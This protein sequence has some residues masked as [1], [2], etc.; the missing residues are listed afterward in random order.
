MT[1]AAATVGVST[2]PAPSTAYRPGRPGLESRVTVRLASL[3]V[4]ARW[5]TV[6]VTVLRAC[7]A[8]MVRVST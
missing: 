5:P 7:W 6:T 8:V 3:S 1:P 2:A 4:T